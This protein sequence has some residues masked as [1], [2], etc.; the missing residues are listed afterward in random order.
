[1]QADGRHQ[2]INQQ[3]APLAGAH[4]LQP[5]QRRQRQQQARRRN[6]QHLP[7]EGTVQAVFPGPVPAGEAGRQL[8]AQAVAEADDGEGQTEKGHQLGQGWN[9]GGTGPGGDG[10]PE[11]VEGAGVGAQPAVHPGGVA[12]QRQNDEEPERGQGGINQ[13]QGAEELVGDGVEFF[14]GRHIG[15]AANPAGRQGAEAAPNLVAG[16]PVR[17]QPVEKG[18]AA[19][20]AEDGAEAA[21][22]EEG[23]HLPAQAQQAAQVH[24]QGQEE[25]AGRQQIGGAERVDLGAEAGGNQ[26]AAV[27]TGGEKA[28]EHQTGHDAVETLPEGVGAGAGG[29]DEAEQAEEQADGGGN[30]GNQRHGQSRGKSRHC[31]RE[32]QRREG[33]SASAIAAPITGQIVRLRRS[34]SF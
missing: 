23:Q 34:A 14:Q 2:H 9:A 4:R 30:G 13:Q 19:E 5:A 15:R 25:E 18:K 32:G 31:G 11:G 1:M 6:R 21:G 12:H 33:R 27:E 20:A 29:E 3:R 26:A 22:E 24:D 8:A 7:E 28:T 17:G 10:F 16:E